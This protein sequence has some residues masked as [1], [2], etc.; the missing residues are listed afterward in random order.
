MDR[1][2]AQVPEALGIGREVVIGHLK[3]LFLS[4][5]VDIRTRLL[6][7]QS[8]DPAKGEAVRAV[9]KNLNAEESAEL[10]A[11]VLQGSG[12][13]FKRITGI[14]DL[15][16]KDRAPRGDLLTILKGKMD[17][18]RTGGPEQAGWREVQRIL[19]EESERYISDSY[20]RELDQAFAG[21]GATAGPSSCP[22]WNRRP[23]PSGPSGWWWKPS[24]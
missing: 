24:C 5:P 21:G 13:S 14:L 4:L 17:A 12:G 7:L 8:R 2:L 9:M 6:D 19:S 16:S 3:E 18:A 15:L 11:S 10:V 1:T 23:S 22:N 20:G